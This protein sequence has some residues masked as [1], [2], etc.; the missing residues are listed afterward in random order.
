MSFA[1]PNTPDAGQTPTQAKDGLDPSQNRFTQGLLSDFGNAY[2][3]KSM[4]SVLRDNGINIPRK[5]ELKMREQYVSRTAYMEAIIIGII[6]GVGLGVTLFVYAFDDASE[7]AFLSGNKGDIERFAFLAV[8]LTIGMWVGHGTTQGGMRC[9]PTNQRVISENKA[10]NFCI[11]DSDC[12]D[13]T[14]QGSGLGL[15]KRGTDHGYVGIARSVG[16]YLSP[17][18]MV[19]LLVSAHLTDGLSISAGHRTMATFF[20]ISVGIIYQVV[21]SNYHKVHAAPS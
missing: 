19:V 21:F 11:D 18:L 2:A 20:G 7:F 5:I 4:A 13:H 1:N 15:C 3:G 6:V 16:K 14:D 9:D 10:Y 8:G 17:L 12:T